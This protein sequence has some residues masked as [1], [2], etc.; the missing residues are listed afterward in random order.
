MFKEM[1]VERSNPFSMLE[2][3]NNNIKNSK[4]PYTE[5]E[6]KLL[7]TKCVE[8]CDDLRLIIA[9]MIDTGCKASE[10]VGMHVED[11]NLNSHLPF[12]I[13]RSNTSRKILRSIDKRTI[14]LVGIS[15][16]AAKTKLKKKNS[17]FLFPNYCSNNKNTIPSAENSINK[18]LKENIPEK[19]I[20]S[21]RL[22]I[23]NRLKKIDCPE[24][25]ILDIVGKSKFGGS[26]I[27]S[28]QNTLEMKIG[29]MSQIV[30][31]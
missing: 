29:W 17:S 14:P 11:V 25:I 28:R 21:F 19:T 1:N 24:E 13:I 4:K 18:W 9:M 27:Y 23:I 20:Y 12:I 7:Q 10:I 30:L 16:W 22:A 6:L 26:K 8:L 31:K 2:W 15:L 3:P 5:T